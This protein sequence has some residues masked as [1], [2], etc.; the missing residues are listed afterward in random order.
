MKTN[1]HFP[2]FM[3]ISKKNVL[4]VG[5]GA[6]AT[7]RIKGLLPFVS[8]ISVVAPQM[9]KELRDLGLELIE[10]EFRIEDLNQKDIVV[11]ASDDK[12][13]NE[14]I[15]QLCTHKEII[16]NVATAPE[17]CDF[18]FPGMIVG[19]DYVIGMSSGGES[20]G[21]TKDLREKIQEYL[22]NES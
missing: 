6:V 7:R 12:I 14:R 11:I 22:Q 5:G 18:Y 4:V 3:D 2:M 19:E 21:R 1:K 10:R 16:K 17:L 13:L 20:P 8:N 9:N 15:A